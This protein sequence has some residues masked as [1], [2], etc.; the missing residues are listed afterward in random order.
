METTPPEEK[1]RSDLP[2]ELGFAL[3]PRE[4]DPAPIV[5]RS[6]KVSRAESTSAMVTSRSALRDNLLL[7]YSSTR[8][9]A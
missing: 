3:A 8:R 6:S 9:V 5:T 7:E 4:S 2:S 1:C